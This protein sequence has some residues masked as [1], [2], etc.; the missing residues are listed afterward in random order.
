M[1]RALR[2]LLAAAGADGIFRVCVYSLGEEAINVRS[3]LF[4]VFRRHFLTR[5][6]AKYVI[7][8]FCVF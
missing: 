6:V 5:C 8:A 2:G 1:R 7:T 4:T 3:Y